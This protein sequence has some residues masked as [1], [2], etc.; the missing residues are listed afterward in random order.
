MMT[1]HDF[2]AIGIETDHDWI[3]ERTAFTSDTSASHRDDYVDG[4]DCVA[5][6][7][8]PR[9]GAPREIDAIVLSPLP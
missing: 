3:V 7:H 8:A 1:N 2:A 9:G 4:R 6:R 5:R